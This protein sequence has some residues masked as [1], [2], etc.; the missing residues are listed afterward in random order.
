M[1]T[2]FKFAVLLLV[3]SA[4]LQPRSGAFAQDAV[5]TYQGRV[6][7]HGTNFTGIGQFKFALVTSANDNRAATASATI[8]G[9]FVTVIT[10]IDGGSGY[11]APPTVTLSGG[12]GAGASA[13]S[14]L[15]AG[16]VASITVKNVG[17]GYTSAPTVTLAPPPPDYRYLTYWSHDGSSFA[18][19]EPSTAVNAVVANGLFTIGL[20]DSS[21]ANMT[22]LSA[23]LFQ[24]PNLQ[25]RIW[26]SD[27]AKG[28]A[29]LA[30]LQDLTAAP[31]AA[32]AAVAASAAQLTGN[33]PTSQL[34]GT[35]PASQLT[36]SFPASQL[37]GFL[38]TSQLSGDWP[39]SQLSGTIDP[40]RLPSMVVMGYGASASG[41]DSTAMG[42]ACAATNIYSTAMGYQT[43][44]GGLASTAMGYQTLAS[45]P[46]STA[47]GDGTK[48]LGASCTAM[49][50]N[51]T[52]SGPYA[53][54]L[55]ADTV[56]SG[57]R[58]AA[59]G[60]GAHADGALSIALGNAT[61]ATGDSSTAMGRG[62]KA[63]GGSSTA[64]GYGTTASGI[65]ATA[66]GINS[67]ASGFDALT[68]GGGTAASGDYSTAMGQNT[69]AS[70]NTATAMGIGTK[71]TKDRST[72]MGGGTLASG[73]NSTATGQNTIASGFASITTGVDT[74]AGGDYST[75]LGHGSAAGGESST[76]MGVSTSAAGFAATALGVGSHANH[77]NTFVW[78]DGT[79]ASP[80]AS[81]SANQFL[82]Y[83][84]GGVGIGTG[85][86]QSA[87]HVKSTVID[88]EISIESGDAGG[89]RWTLQSSAPGGGGQLASSFQL[90]DRSVGAS[91]ILV[92][93]SG[94]VGIG[95]AS[96]GYLLQVAGNC[97]ATTFVTVSDRNAKENFT[98]VSPRS[99]LDKVAALPISQWNFKTAPGEAH[100][101]PMA[102]DFYAAFGAG[103]D[104]KHIATVDADGVALAAIQGLNQKVE[105]LRAEL[106]RKD[107][108]NAALL[109]RLEALE[110]RVGNP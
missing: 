80:F 37:S 95:T 68:T 63:L 40:A 39:A 104:D 97:G 5:V 64:M 15:N 1:K 31:Y 60:A 74:V 35:F 109:R 58:S 59:M 47:M 62:A 14:V 106:S 90:I 27:D 21:V 25:L 26:F 88:C 55:G 13:T 44:S 105:E 50:I 98:P 20:G 2:N 87:L 17:S 32:H 91:R 86:P 79:P 100:I 46:V 102:Q 76:A 53:T 93:T 7:D 23:A 61:Q 108:E 38:P 65:N 94:N 103:A 96:P 85:S 33:L 49:G 10:V 66:M 29:A 24:Q 6:T 3:S 18:G 36:G 101:G 9:G 48:A 73:V 69:T 19:S 70:G 92:D 43:I 84:A 51:T 34:N 67:V 22:T 72:A 75:A 12:G 107:V 89:H 30:P 57:D 110:K 4:L 28:F 54:A 52:A 78:S 83:A 82:L 45:G 16:V 56:A 8:S 11:T 41:S 99:V 71:A 42:Y 77:N 81:S